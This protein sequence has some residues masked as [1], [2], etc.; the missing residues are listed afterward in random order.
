LGGK[1]A[2]ASQLPSIRLL[3]GDA[4]DVR[5]ADTLEDYVAALEVDWEVWQVD[6]EKRANRR[7]LEAGRF[8]EMNATGAVHHLSVF[9]RLL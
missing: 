6:E 9:R 3:R 4:V 5:R 8:R 1:E 2:K 7:E